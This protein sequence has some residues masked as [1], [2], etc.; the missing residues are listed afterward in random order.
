M[1]TVDTVNPD[2]VKSFSMQ[3]EIIRQ[4]QIKDGQTP[5]YATPTSDRCDN[6]ECGWRHDCF[7]EAR[8]HRLKSWRRGCPADAT[9]A[10]QKF[11]HFDY[12]LLD[13]TQQGCE[14]Q[15]RPKGGGAK[16]PV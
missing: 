2:E 3:A 4:I 8:E 16:P 14:G 6:K 11:A 15:T 12:G 10:G 1:N 7:D 5:C 9:A 13:S